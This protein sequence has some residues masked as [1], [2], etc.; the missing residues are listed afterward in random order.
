MKKIILFLA[1]FSF[2]AS[3]AQDAQ[4]VEITPKN[5]WFKAGLITGIPTSDVKDSTP[6]SFGVDVRAQYMFNNHFAIGGATGYNH[7]FVKD[8]FEDF[9]VVPLAGY[10]RFYFQK[11][12]VFVGT[13]VGVAFVTNVES[14]SRGLYFNPQIGYHN[15][16]WNIYGF[17]QNTFTENTN[18]RSLGVGVTYNIRFK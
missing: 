9:G 8:D 4:K 10:A 3:Y 2:G 5:S 6:L 18:I 7:F 14:D 15:R 17:Y 13:D 16:D 11:E 1:A 12:G